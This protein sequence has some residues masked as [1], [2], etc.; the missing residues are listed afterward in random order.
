VKA[1]ME[2]HE[3]FAKQEWRSAWLAAHRAARF[4]LGAGIVGR[5]YLGDGFEDPVILNGGCIF[6]AHR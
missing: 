4:R 1:T 6:W 2:L 5:L 3:E